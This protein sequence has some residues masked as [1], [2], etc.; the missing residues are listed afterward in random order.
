[1][2]KYDPLYPPY[3][4]ASPSFS[5]KRLIMIQGM[6][7]E[8]FMERVIDRNSLYTPYRVVNA[9]LGKSNIERVIVRPL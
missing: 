3:E 6:I 7:Q 8:Y 5:Y 2:V 9:D 1:M 4:L